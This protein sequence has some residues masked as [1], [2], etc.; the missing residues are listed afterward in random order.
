VI[1]GT[2]GL[3]QIIKVPSILN[4]I[5]PYY[6]ITFILRH[7]Y[8]SIITIGCVFLVVTGG[9][10]LYADIGHFGK[11]PIRF[12]WFTIV[13]P[14]LLLNYFGQGAF[15]LI[16][17]GM[18][19]NTFFQIS[20]AWFL[21]FLVAISTIAGIIAS[22]AIISAVFSIIK[23]TVL[24]NFLPRLKIVQTSLLEKGQVYLPMVNAFLA[25]GT[26]ALV[27]GFES[28]T[29]LTNAYGFAVNLD[30]IITTIFVGI[31]AAYKWKWR[32]RL[33]L[34]FVI[35]FLDL[36]Y[37]V[38]NSHKILDGGW[39]PLAIAGFIAVLMY[40]WYRG[41]NRLHLLNH[42]NVLLDR[43]ILEDLNQNKVRRLPGT[44]LFIT[45]PYDYSGGSLLHHLKINH[46][47]SERVIFLGVVIDDHPYVPLRKRFEIEEKAEGFYFL[48]IHYGFTEDINLPDILQNLSQNASLPFQLDDVDTMSFFIEIIGLELSRSSG[49][50]MPYWQ[51]TLFA[52][53]LKNALPDIQFYHLPYNRTVAI[54]TYYNL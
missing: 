53:M 33:G 49:G 6:A 21:P 31:I 48:T 47:L 22:Q 34:F 1:I 54:G 44:A 14:G 8:Q 51:K 5:N 52:F 25:V 3:I 27:L 42:R 2:L 13:F 4:A 7:G 50:N 18:S 26:C 16:H 17:P 23:Q 30:M 41:F 35:F 9:E 40:V 24:L 15:L 46:M 12:S 39:I 11:N 28:T 37:L 38:G 36:A 45:D 19:T 20:P 43:T 29:R 32:F 10:A